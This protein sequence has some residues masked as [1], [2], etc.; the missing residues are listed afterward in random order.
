MISPDEY[1]EQGLNDQ[2]YDRKSVANQRWFRR[3]RFA[4]IK[5]LVFTMILQR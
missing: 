5:V 1:I 3:L 2:M 4:E